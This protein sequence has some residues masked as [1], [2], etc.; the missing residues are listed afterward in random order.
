[1]ALVRT[2][3]VM[4]VDLFE[5]QAGADTTNG[6][7]NTR[8][9]ARLSRREL[10]RRHL[11]NSR[12]PVVVQGRPRRSLTSPA[13]WRTTSSTSTHL[14][15]SI[16]CVTT[17]RSPASCCSRAVRGSRRFPIGAR[18]G[19]GAEGLRR[20]RPG[21]APGPCSQPTR[22]TRRG[23]NRS[24]GTGSFCGWLPA[25]GLKHEVQSIAAL[26]VHRVWS[27]RPAGARWIWVPPIAVPLARSM[28]ARLLSRSAGR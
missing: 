8:E 17:S 13:V 26:E 22:C 15:S 11:S 10:E 16:T 9:Y 5:D 1:M 24:V 28:R 12:L 19:C 7:E 18:P 25:S 6:I 21:P 3:P 4:T 23:G 14:I 2:V 27:P 20:R